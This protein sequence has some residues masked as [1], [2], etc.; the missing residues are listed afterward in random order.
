MK[1][2]ILLALS[3]I[4]IIIIV[5]QC[6]CIRSQGNQIR[7]LNKELIHIQTCREAMDAVKQIDRMRKDLE[8]RQKEFEKGIF[9]LK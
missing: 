9:D 5:I 1:H 6:V 7:R 3:L 8:N 2:T 4:L